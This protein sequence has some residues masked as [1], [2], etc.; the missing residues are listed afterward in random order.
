MTFVESFSLSRSQPSNTWKDLLSELFSLNWLG[1]RKHLT[2]PPVPRPVQPYCSPS[3]KD[4]YQLNNTCDVAWTIDQVSE[5]SGDEDFIVQMSSSLLD[6]A[7]NG[8]IAS[9]KSFGF[10][11]TNKTKIA[12]AWKTFLSRLLYL[13]RFR[14]SRLSSSSAVPRPIRCY[15]ISTTLVSSLGPP[16]SCLG[17]L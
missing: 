14:S 16:K 5:L 7:L 10:P 2:T 12:A 17:G 4:A 13:A 15:I 6:D 8:K 1:S 11:G 3:E 9:A